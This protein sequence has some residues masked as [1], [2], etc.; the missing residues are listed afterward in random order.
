ML[1]LTLSH[2]NLEMDQYKSEFIPLQRIGWKE[3]GI[4]RRTGGWFTARSSP[5]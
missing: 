1:R 3:G 5:V 2:R 4:L